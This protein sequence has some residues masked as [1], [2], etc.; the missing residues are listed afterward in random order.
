[1]VECVYTFSNVSYKM[2]TQS[3]MKVLHHTTSSECVYTFPCSLLRLTPEFCNYR[4]L[5]HFAMAQPSL[6]VLV[7]TECVRCL[8]LLAQTKMATI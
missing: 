4:K 8:W 7:Q 2:Y 6:L 1:M 5:Q 3:T